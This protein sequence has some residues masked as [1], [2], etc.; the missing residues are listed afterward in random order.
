[1]LAMQIKRLFA[2][3]QFAVLAATGSAFAATVPVGKGPNGI[4]MAP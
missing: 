4:S 3:T 1:M 2:V